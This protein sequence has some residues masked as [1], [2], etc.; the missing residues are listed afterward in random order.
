MLQ[1]DGGDIGLKEQADIAV[2][3]LLVAGHTAVRGALVGAIVTHGFK[4]QGFFNSLISGGVAA[5]NE[6]KKITDG[7]KEPDAVNDI[8]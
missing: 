3:Q 4:H 1:G 5:F 6:V 2:W 8:Q 7:K